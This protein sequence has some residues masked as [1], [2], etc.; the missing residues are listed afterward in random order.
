[1]VGVRACASTPEV[2][3]DGD[4]NAVKQFLRQQTKFLRKVEWRDP[5]RGVSAEVRDH[6]ILFKQSPGNSVV[7]PPGI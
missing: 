3:Q 6:N 5:R 4:A 2:R 7:L 1:M